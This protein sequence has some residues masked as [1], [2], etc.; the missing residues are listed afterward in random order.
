MTQYGSLINML[1]DGVA[2]FD[3]EVGMGATILMWTD[4][5]PA[6]IVK[7]DRFKS[8][9]RK[10]EVKAVWIT[11]DIATRIDS[12]GMSES[13]TYTF[14]TDPDAGAVQYT[15]RSDGRFKMAGSDS[16]VS[17]RVGSRDKYRDYSF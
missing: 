4:R 2:P 15:K 14:T 9:P 6:T 13:Q 7:V 3:P 8:G 12:N 16:G 10:G 1:S 5:E 17:L 11:R